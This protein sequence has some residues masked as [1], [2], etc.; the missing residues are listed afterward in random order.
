MTRHLMAKLR[1]YVTRWRAKKTGLKPSLD[2]DA[3]IRYMADDH[4]RWFA[5]YAQAIMK[6][7][8]PE[9]PEAMPNL[10]VVL[11][12][13]FWYLGVAVRENRLSEGFYQVFVGDV[14]GL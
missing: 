11:G 14:L 8:T 10:T 13:A 5:R 4:F 12:F 9:H 2:F 1:P 3:M 7:E 6:N